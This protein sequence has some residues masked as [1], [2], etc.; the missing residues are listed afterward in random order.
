MS[1]GCPV[2][3]CLFYACFLLFFIN[4]DAF[5]MT[6]TVNP[7]TPHAAVGKST[8]RQDAPDKL[9]GRARYAGDLALP[10]LL[11]ARLVLSP[12]AHA[13][14]LKIDTSAAE[15]IPGVQAV[16]TSETLG[17]AKRDTSS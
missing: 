15:A 9:T 11:H 14:I 10:G 6:Q 17:M 1:Q 3:P 2:D 16:Y 7:K 4:G 13:R 5:S 8:R 12:Y